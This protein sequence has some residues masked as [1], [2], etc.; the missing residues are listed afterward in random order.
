[1]VWTSL[2]AQTV[3]P[4]PTM[5]ETCIVQVSIQPTPVFL[6]GKSR[7]W[8]S[9][10]GYSS[11]G[12]KE[13]DVT[14]RLHFFTS[15]PSS[16]VGTEHCMVILCHPWQRHEEGTGGVW[17]GGGGKGSFLSSLHTR[18]HKGSCEWYKDSLNPG[19][20]YWAYTQPCVCVCVLSHFSHGWL[21]AT[22]W[23][24]A[25]QAPLSMGFSRQVY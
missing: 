21:F 25:H 16:A 20:A 13:S 6:P 1:M 8:R 14:E 19:Q 17:I 12:R 22:L 23:I 5:W 10:E 7:G 3:K 9:L 2:V 18:R 11:W 15:L 24:V 4:L